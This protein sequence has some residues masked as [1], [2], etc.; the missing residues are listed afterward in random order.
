MPGGWQSANKATTLTT[1]K[2]RLT[3]VRTRLL[4]AE[5]RRDLLLCFALDS[6]WYR[7]SAAVAV[8]RAD[9]AGSAA[10]V[11]V[12]SGSRALVVPYQRRGRWG[13]RESRC[14]GGRERRRERKRMSERGAI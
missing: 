2:G 5:R 12:G 6:Y 3:R 11:L 13:A 8:G 10:A 14:E 4:V 9:Q 7:F 1:L